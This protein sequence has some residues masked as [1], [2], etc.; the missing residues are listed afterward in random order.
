E[1]QWT[2]VTLVD[3][4]RDVPGVRRRPAASIFVP[5][6][7]RG[8][9]V[10]SSG[11]NPFQLRDEVAPLKG[12]AIRWAALDREGL[13]VYVFVV[14]EDGRYEMQTYTR[15]LTD[16]GLE[17]SF[18]RVVDGKVERRMSGRAVRAE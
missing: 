17:L 4:R 18:E 11:F 12:D 9:F 14:L 1:I 2:N 8:F 10:E 7:D 16:T 5:A 3:G 6:K 13:H 15:R